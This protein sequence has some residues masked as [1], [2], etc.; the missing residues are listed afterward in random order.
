MTLRARRGAI[1]RGKVIIP[2][3]IQPE[4]CVGWGLELWQEG[5]QVGR[6]MWNGYG[7][8]ATQALKP[9]TYVVRITRDRVARDTMA[10]SAPIAVEAG[11]VVD[12]VAI[13]LSGEA[14]K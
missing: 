9:G 7:T 6:I 12:D 3:G 14:G 13:S 2:P 10:E 1:I 11:E 5:H 8:F 4:A